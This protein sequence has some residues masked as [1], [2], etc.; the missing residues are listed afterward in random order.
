MPISPS[1]VT[2][3]EEINS[4][5]SSPLET[6]APTMSQGSSSPT[7]FAFELPS[8]KLTP[9]TGLTYTPSTG[10]TYSHQLSGY[11]SASS[12]SSSASGSYGGGA[13]SF[14]STDALPAISRD[15]SRPNVQ[16]AKRPATAGGLLQ[17]RAPLGNFAEGIRKETIQEGFENPFNST[18]DNSPY[19]ANGLDPRYSTSAR[20]ASEG[21][22][23]A[24]PPPSWPVQ[25]NQGHSS[26]PAHTN[27]FDPYQINQQA[28]R[29]SYSNS[30]N[31]PQTSDG[32][33]S[34]GGP[35]PLPS[36]RSVVG[37][38]SN[39][40]ASVP[41]L[42]P[43]AHIR[44]SYEDS[45]MPFRDRSA[46]TSTS[47]SDGD[48]TFVPIGGPVPKKR[49][50]RRFDEIERLYRCGWGG[51]E[52]SYGTL[53]HLNAHVAMQQH[54]EKRLPSGWSFWTGLLDWIDTDW[55]RI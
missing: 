2:P 22:G 19:S 18:A 20:R 28:Y 11:S 15:F 27:T 34:F 5:W 17:S 10:S 7:D 54:G 45:T 1:V 16:Q 4:D 46:Y 49:P 43:P 42:Q 13:S 47:R 8:D 3:D 35:T 40:P 37:P 51:C 52:K 53:N 24:M 44:S 30:S 31:R 48:L 36:A 55:Y 6:S 32:L 50:R 23:S 26:A 14:S 12:F 9:L 21:Q 41:A 29:S 25:A 39:M 33:P 38:L